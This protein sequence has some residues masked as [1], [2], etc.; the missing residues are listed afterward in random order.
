[1]L[2][3]GG[4][5]ADDP[6]QSLNEAL[7]TK[8]CP[9]GGREWQARS[10]SRGGVRGPGQTSEKRGSHCSD[11]APHVGPSDCSYCK[12]GS[13]GRWEALLG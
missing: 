8:E 1:M 11:S 4:C 12:E 3:G 6:W 2:G 7:P 10:Q 13:F 5:W 9:V